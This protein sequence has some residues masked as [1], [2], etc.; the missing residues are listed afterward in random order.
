MGAY[1][2]VNRI[3]KKKTIFLLLFHC[4]FNKCLPDTALYLSSCQM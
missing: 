1:N 3:W 2:E 4:C